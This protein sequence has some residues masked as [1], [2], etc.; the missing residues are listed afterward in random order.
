[1]I[2]VSKNGGFVELGF[3]VDRPSKYRLCVLAPAAPDYAKIQIAQD[4]YAVG[5]F[6]LHSGRVSPSGSLELGNHDLNAGSHSLRFKVVGKNPASA[7]HL[8][9]IDA[10]DLLDE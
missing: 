1:M 3:K 10:I 8:F 7:G 4:G 2:C 5:E 9:G 6:D